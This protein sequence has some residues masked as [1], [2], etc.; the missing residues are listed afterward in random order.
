VNWLIHDLAPSINDFY[1]SSVSMKEMDLMITIDTATA[2]QAGA[3]G[4]PVWLMLIYYS[5]WRW[6]A[7]E[8]DTTRWYPGMRIFRQDKHGSWDL[9][10]DELYNAFEEWVVQSLPT[11]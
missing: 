5:D 4:V 9:V 2:H 6:G 8:N 11:T 10:A 7:V 1:D 3:L